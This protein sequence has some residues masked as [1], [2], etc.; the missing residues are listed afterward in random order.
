M[1]FPSMGLPSLWARDLPFLLQWTLV[2]LPH[3]LLKEQFFAVY[4]CAVGVSPS[5]VGTRRQ[6]AHFLFYPRRAVLGWVRYS[7]FRFL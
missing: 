2:S 4:G 7:H 3:M 6:G 5:S 1:C